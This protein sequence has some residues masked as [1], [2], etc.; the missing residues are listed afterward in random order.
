MPNPL[1]SGE[2]LNRLKS[3]IS[4]PWSIVYFVTVFVLYCSIEFLLGRWTILSRSK[5]MV[6][7]ML[8]LPLLAWAG[9]W[10][11]LLLSPY[12]RQRPSRRNCWVIVL[13][14]AAVFFSSLIWILILANL[15]GT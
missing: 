15:Y 10:L 1:I 7:L 4:T 9:F 12:L 13:S 6:S 11:A 2:P 14:L 5:S 8:A 3:Y